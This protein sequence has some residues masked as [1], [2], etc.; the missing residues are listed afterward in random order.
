MTLLEE[1]GQAYRTALE[2]YLAGGGEDALIEA[3]EIGRRSL[4]NG[5]G[6]LELAGL[7]QAATLEVLGRPGRGDTAD[8]FRAAEA[9]LVECLSPFEMSYRSVAEANAAL[10]RVNDLLEDEA[11]RIAHAL[12]DQAG[13]ILATAGL[14]LD[15]AA[16]QLPAE[17]RERLLGV[18]RLVDETGEQLRHLS[19]ELRP[20]I[21]DDLGL[22]PALEFLTQGV[23][24]RTGLTVTLRGSI[25]E[26]PPAPIETAVY[27][28]VQEA[29]NNIVL[30]GGGQATVAVTLER[31]GERIRCTVVD[32]GSGFDVKLAGAN[33]G[34]RGLGLLG[35]RERARAVGGVCEV[36]SVPGRGT[37]ICVTVPLQRSLGLT[38][39]ELQ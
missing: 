18:R 26:R 12:H 7:H 2:C 37:T 31:D 30:H 13:A 25:G 1:I 29:L 15:L 28:I 11:R 5:I 36:T 27:R 20:T 8:F 32:T 4:A 16:D 10:R 17:V 23:E 33:G 38:D 19:H 24:Q 35:M 21:L 22:L 3:Y 6:I 14:E 9:F 34:R 39:G